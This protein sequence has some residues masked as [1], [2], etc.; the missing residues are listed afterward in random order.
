VF[1]LD[2]F[3]IDSDERVGEGGFLALRRLRMRNRRVDGTASTPYVC[4]GV[5]RPY[6]QAAVVVA[7]YTRSSGRI[8]VLVRECLRPV[9][10]GFTEGATTHALIE[11]RELMTGLG[12][13]GT[14]QRSG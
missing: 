9:L 4:D 8:E 12:G 13:E 7:I 11:A 1:E 2:S 6:G 14:G 10:D 3:I 5:V